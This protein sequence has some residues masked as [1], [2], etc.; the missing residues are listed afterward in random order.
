LSRSVTSS[1]LIFL[2]RS[3]LT[4]YSPHPRPVPWVFAT[5]T[6]T[7]IHRRR[8]FWDPL[9]LQPRLFALVPPTSSPRVTIFPFLYRT[10][11]T[12]IKSRPSSTLRLI[13]FACCHF[14]FGALADPQLRGLPVQRP[15]TDE[16][17]RH[18]L[19]FPLLQYSKSALQ[20]SDETP[21]NS[22]SCFCSLCHSTISI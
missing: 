20:P 19:I 3:S 16:L 7:S 14:L 21:V 5:P 1:D 11:R 18:S 9:Q 8:F 17:R 6:S 22:F 4:I 2:L 12:R 10:Q 13:S 15:N